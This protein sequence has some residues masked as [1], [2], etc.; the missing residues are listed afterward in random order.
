MNLAQTL[1]ADPTFSLMSRAEK[2]DEARAIGITAGMEDD[3]LAFA[4]AVEEA[5]GLVAAGKTDVEP[6]Q[7]LPAG[8]E[9]CREDR[10]SCASPVAGNGRCLECGAR[11]APEQ[12]LVQVEVASGKSE[13]SPLSLEPVETVT[14]KI[15][16][17]PVDFT[18]PTK[19]SAPV[20]ARFKAVT[21]NNDRDIGD[22]LNMA[23]STV[24]ATVGGRMPEKLTPAQLN[25]VYMTLLARAK[26]AQDLASEL[27]ERIFT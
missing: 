5:E 16:N 2:L 15:G 17:H 9:P 10:A 12:M 8:I 14:A 4:L 18:A 23:R 1:I 7:A 20:L 3:D 11:R 21:G 19:P 24:Q 13:G 22:L 25:R 27:E 6:V 26:A